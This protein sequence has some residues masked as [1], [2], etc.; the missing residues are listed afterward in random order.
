MYYDGHSIFVPRPFIARTVINWK[1]TLEIPRSVSSTMAPN[2]RPTS[3][4]K[5]L[6]SLP[7]PLT[8]PTDNNSPKG[9]E[10]QAKE[11]KR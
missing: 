6:S 11:K 1:H 5:A 2:L 4:R 9:M 10:E 8:P 7:L 3:K